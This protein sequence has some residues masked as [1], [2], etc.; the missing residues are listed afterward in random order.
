LYDRQLAVQSAVWISTG[1]LQAYFVHFP[2]ASQPPKL[3]ETWL[4]D[5]L[6]AAGVQHGTNATAIAKLALK[7]PAASKKK[8]IVIASATQPIPGQDTYVDYPF[9]PEKRA[10]K[11]MPDGSIDLR[12][13]NAVVGVE[14]NQSLGTVIPATEGIPG[15]DLRGEHIPTI[16]GTEKTFKA[17]ENVRAEGNPPHAFFAKITGNVNLTGDTINVNEVFVVSGDV[18]YETGNIDTPKDVQVDGNISTGFTVKAGGS[19]TVGG[20]VEAG[21]TV[22]ARGDITVAQGIVGEGTT[23]TAQGVISHGCVQSKFIQN[24]TVMAKTDVGVGSYIYNSL[25]RSGGE[26]TVAFEGGE[27]GGS[28]VGGEVYASKAIRCRTIGSASTSGTIIGIIPA[29]EKN[30][31]IAKLDKAINFCE[32]NILRLLRTMGLQT[33]DAARIKAVLR[34]APPAKQQV[35]VDIVKKLYELVEKREESNLKRNSLEQEIDKALELG[36]I[37]VEGTVF[38]GVQVLINKHNFNTNQEIKGVAIFKTP[39]GIRTRPIFR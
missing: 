4:L 28:I 37:S 36:L 16:S 6:N 29:P 24:A 2:Q 5:A 27:R 22:S 34:Q 23:V 21:A 35:M 18:N 3:Q 9:E 39:D 8:A 10:G 33:V 13:R 14:E 11:I 26:V 31:M 15:T 17:G 1:Q 30:A 38:A 12:E 25:V 32:A 19:I 7:L 20:L